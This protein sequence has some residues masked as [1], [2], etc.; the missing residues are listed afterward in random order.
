MLQK[1]GFS[2]VAI[3]ESNSY[4]SGEKLQVL[5]VSWLSSRLLLWINFKFLI[6]QFHT[7]LSVCI[8]FNAL[9]DTLFSSHFE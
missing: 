9:S 8:V 7:F 6:D 2:N 4:G 1:A 5:N 3:L